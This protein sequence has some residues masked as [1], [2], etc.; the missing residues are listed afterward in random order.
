VSSGGGEKLCARVLG[1]L[2]PTITYGF[3]KMSVS[4]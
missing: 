3:V 1:I 2:N 4:T